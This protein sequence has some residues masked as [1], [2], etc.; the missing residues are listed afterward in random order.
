MLDMA[1]RGIQELITLQKETLVVTTASMIYASLKKLV[2]LPAITKRKLREIES[3]LAPLMQLKFSR[4]PD[5]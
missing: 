1:Q 5:I 4:N 3:I 2:V